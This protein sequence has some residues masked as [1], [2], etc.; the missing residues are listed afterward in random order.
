MIFDKVSREN[1]IQNYSKE[2]FFNFYLI[3]RIK[4]LSP[5]LLNWIKSKQEW[6]LL[7][8]TCERVSGEL[9][10]ALE[11]RKKLKCTSSSILYLQKNFLFENHLNTTEL[12]PQENRILIEYL[13]NLKNKKTAV[14]IIFWFS[15]PWVG[16]NVQW[17]DLRR[18]SLM[19]DEQ[20]ENS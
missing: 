11:E 10:P 20:I 7:H 13:S 9:S 17:F 14:V 12:I 18:N 8:L 15:L 3:L 1:A 2:Q 6:K 4:E 5:I 16:K 19:H